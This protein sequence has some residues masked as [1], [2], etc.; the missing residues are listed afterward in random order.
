MLALQNLKSGNCKKALQY[1][2]DAKQWPERL[3]SGKPYEAD[4]DDRL[5]DWLSYDCLVK[6]RNS[7]AAAQKLNDIIGFATPA[8]A[9]P[10]VN[11]VV[12]AWA[13]KK[14]GK[15][16]EKFLKDVLVAHPSNKVAQWGLDVFS[17]KSATLDVENNEEY[18]I[19]S[20]WLALQ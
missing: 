4:I 8:T 5:E 15:D 16:G 9:R 7:K 20:Q 17:G 13:L 19:L 10:S 12:T 11:N 6:S 14:N 2:D 18:V 1:I 3:G